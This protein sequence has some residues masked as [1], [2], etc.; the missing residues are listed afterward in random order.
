MHLWSSMSPAAC[1]LRQHQVEPGPVLLWT[2]YGSGWIHGSVGCWQS[3]FSFVLKK[4]VCE[5]YSNYIRCPTKAHRCIHV[6]HFSLK[7]YSWCTFHQ[8]I[9]VWHKR[10][11]MTPHDGYLS[12]FIQSS[13]SEMDIIPTNLSKRLQT[14]PLWISLQP[15]CSRP[16]TCCD[17]DPHAEFWIEVVWNKL[18]RMINTQTMPNNND[19]D[20][21][22]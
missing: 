1:I 10:I 2:H 20:E 3:S 15:L 16:H 18:M 12:C 6:V 5:N 7:F 9:A 21:L 11:W 19:A 13:L 22:L 14:P 8:K 4:I 17:S